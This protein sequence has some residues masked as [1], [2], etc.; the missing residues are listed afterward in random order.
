MGRTSNKV[1]LFYYLF[2]ITLVTSCVHRVAADDDRIVKRFNYYERNYFDSFILEDIEN[3]PKQDIKL[4]QYEAHYRNGD[5]QSIVGYYHDS[6]QVKFIDSVENH[7]ITRTRYFGINGG[8]IQDKRLV[9][10]ANRLLKIEVLEKTTSGSTTTIL[11]RFS[12]NDSDRIEY[13]AE[14]TFVSKNENRSLVST[15]FFNIRMQP[16][17]IS[18]VLSVSFADSDFQ[19]SETYTYNSQGLLTEYRAVSDEYGEIQHY[20]YYYDK[21]RLIK[22]LEITDFGEFRRE[23]IY[24]DGHETEY[25]NISGNEMKLYMEIK[26]LY[27]R[28][29]LKFCEWESLTEDGLT[30][31][32][33]EFQDERVQHVATG[34]ESYSISKELVLDATFL[35]TLDAF[36]H[37]Y[38]ERYYESP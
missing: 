29:M 5:L 21:K 38:V 15:G 7:R 9:W 34:R 33:I 23:T 3:P 24:K 2:S 1:A 31:R 32:A 36:P 28:D 22:K 14:K 16:I 27:I 8:V 19:V 17:Y 30:N 4:L 37:R 26:C 20:E 35:P 12:Y 13:Y 6:D 11:Q 18:S 10:D 25:N